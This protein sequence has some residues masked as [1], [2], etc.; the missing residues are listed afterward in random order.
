[1]PK[2]PRKTTSRKPRARAAQQPPV[3]AHVKAFAARVLE[4]QP[5]GIPVCIPCIPGGPPV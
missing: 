3:P 1:M 4:N 5:L 2:T